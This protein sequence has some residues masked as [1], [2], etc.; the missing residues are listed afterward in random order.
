MEI[1][2]INEINELN[3]NSN[4]FSEIIYDDNRRRNLR[5]PY[6]DPAIGVMIID[7]FG[8]SIQDDF[9]VNLYA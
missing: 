3:F 2:I 9:G 6:I 4:F 8:V 1:K 5:G 7:D